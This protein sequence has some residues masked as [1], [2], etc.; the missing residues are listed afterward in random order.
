MKGVFNQLKDRFLSSISDLSGILPMVS[1]GSSK[2]QYYL[3]MEIKC[4]KFRRIRKLFESERF[5]V[6]EYCQS[7]ILGLLQSFQELFKGR[8]MGDQSKRS[9]NIPTL[10][11]DLD[12]EYDRFRLNL[13]KVTVQKV[14]DAFMKLL[15]YYRLK[16]NLEDKP[17]SLK[18]HDLFHKTGKFLS[19]ISKS[20]LLPLIYDNITQVYR[21]FFTQKLRIQIECILV[22]DGLLF[23][24]ND[25][26]ASF[27]G[28]YSVVFENDLQLL[29]S[30]LI[31]SLKR[32]IDPLECILP[33]KV[34]R[35]QPVDFRY[36]ESLYT[37]M[38]SESL[39]LLDDYLKQINDYV[40]NALEICYKRPDEGL[41]VGDY[42]AFCDSQI[43]QIRKIERIF[44]RKLI[45]TKRGIFNVNIS[46]VCE[47]IDFAIK[48]SLEQQEIRTK[49]YL[50]NRVLLIHNSYNRFFTI[51]EPAKFEQTKKASVMVKEL[52][53]SIPWLID[54]I[55][56]NI[57]MKAYLDNKLWILED[58][59]AE[60][61]YTSC[62]RLEELCSFKDFKREQVSIALEK[63]RLGIG[64]EIQMF[65]TLWS[66]VETAMNKL[67]TLK[68]SKTKTP[69]I[70][71]GDISEEKLQSQTISEEQIV[72]SL[73]YI[74]KHISKA[75]EIANII[76]KKI[77][78]LGNVPGTEE[79]GPLWTLL[80]SRTILVQGLMM[81]RTK[82]SEWMEKPLYS[83]EVAEI[84]REA[85]E[86][87][88][89]M[90]ASDLSECW[91]VESSRVTLETFLQRDLSM[92]KSLKNPILQVLFYFLILG[93]ALGIY[94]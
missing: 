84:E 82:L 83:V 1:S 25:L 9:I 88:S 22:K 91:L 60:Q 55:N 27:N 71:I 33:S 5:H 67:F 65:M 89:V 11:K 51:G 10:L 90:K 86:F 73:S 77:E 39:I 78:L 72:S 58:L 32:W 50:K 74:I 93:M 31:N 92:I 12:V 14:Q 7:I 94:L 37:D 59:D 62:T 54:Q 29:R 36:V 68:S 53:N 81:S 15:S 66:N 18:A 42:C 64:R 79:M 43:E 75:A 8:I 76:S 52:E 21:L 38:V 4:D 48:S 57:Q 40:L 13:T 85:T 24:G 87:I 44:R 61:F 80:K 49:E 23:Q 45:N 6:N 47:C 26:N 56:G 28:K 19:V 3:D 41:S 35:S 70:V 17:K 46:K 34:F 30:E 20:M 2:N 16:E 63:L 69:L